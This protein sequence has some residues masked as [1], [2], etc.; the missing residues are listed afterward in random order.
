MDGRVS[1]IVIVTDDATLIHP[2]GLGRRR[3]NERRLVNYEV[4]WIS[5]ASSVNS[6]SVMQG[7]V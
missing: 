1:V 2:T 7:I 5:V 4:G 6:I 3:T